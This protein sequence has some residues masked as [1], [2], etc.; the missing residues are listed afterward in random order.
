MRVGFLFSTLFVFVSCSSIA[1]KKN[2]GPNPISSK[3]TKQPI[4]SSKKKSDRICKH[5][6]TTLKC[7][8]YVENYDGDTITFNIPNLHRLIGE[9]IY[10]RVEGVD[11]PEIRGK[12]DCEKKKAT[13]AQKLVE[14]LLK[15]AKYIELRNID[16]G[17]YFRIVADVIADGRSVKKEL[18]KTKLGYPYNGKKKR[19]M[20]WCL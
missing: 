9:K 11:T 7:V 20:N 18:L 2:D 1:K 13:R 10:V 5:T 3:S 17:K 6:R 16:R 14:N 15:N 8:E 12:T 19:E 4:L